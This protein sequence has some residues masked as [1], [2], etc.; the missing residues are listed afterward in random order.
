[1]ELAERRRRSR[2]RHADVA[3]EAILHAGQDTFA[4]YG[5]S[6]ARVD[7]IAKASGYNKALLFHYFGDKLGLYQAV[8]GRMKERILEH[9]GGTIERL[10]VASDETP[11]REQVISFV[12]ES[13]RWVFD[14][15]VAHPQTARTLAWEAAEGWHTFAACAPVAGD[16][17]WAERV[18]A[19]LVR[20]QE[21][22]VLRRELDP[23]LLLTTVMSLPLIHLISLPRYEALFTDSDFHSPAA[24]EHAREQMLELVL[25]GTLTTSEEA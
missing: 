1:M 16:R 8:M 9:L 22:G 19:F 11:T 14:Y 23:T 18:R 25:H 13:F 12:T 6:G 2:E 24:L 10:A 4:H 3:R 7:E 20:A 15:Y 5:F 21:A 17:P